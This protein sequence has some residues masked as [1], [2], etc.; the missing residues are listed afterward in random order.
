MLG[1]LTKLVPLK[2]EQDHPFCNLDSLDGLVSSASTINDTGNDYWEKS[3]TPLLDTVETPMHLKN[4][5]LQEL[6]WL[7]EE[8]HAEIIFTLSNT[9][10][11]LKASL[12]LVGLTIL[13]LHYVLNS[14]MEKI[15]WNV[16]EHV[17]LALLLLIIS[18]V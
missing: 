17:Y 6:K 1:I 12:G 7:A 14:P 5:S 8:I 18:F 9:G 11:Q 15:L 13:A 2:Y 4:L 10:S 16:G 3:S